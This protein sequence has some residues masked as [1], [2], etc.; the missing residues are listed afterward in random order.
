MTEVV[1]GGD[2]VRRAVEILAAGGLVGLPTETVY[3]LAGRA[4]DPAACAAIFEAKGRPLSDPLITHLPDPDWLGRVAEPSDVAMRLADAF[5]PGPL[6]MV[7][8]RCPI[9]PDL[10]TAGQPTVAVRVSAHALFADVLRGLGEPVAAPSANR[11][12][13]VSPTCAAHVVEELG[14]RIPLVLDGGDSAHGIESTIVLVSGRQIQI[15]RPGPVGP[16]EL[17]EFGEVL[18][19]TNSRVSVPGSLASHYAPSTPLRLGEAGTGLRP[20]PGLRA[21]LLAWS[22]PQDGF[23]AVEILAPTGHPREA[24]AN[25]Y[26]A[27]RRLDALGL[28]EIVAERPP[29]GGLG[30]AIDDRLNRASAQKS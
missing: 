18:A 5:W 7:L 4:L 24:A 16:A 17:G 25:L 27:I 12:G 13:R 10:V 11:F 2:G 9:V 23:E 1:G 28:D 20:S 30:D 14:G 21:G 19:V 29:T 26:A 6:T 22:D 8:K 15:L 3:G